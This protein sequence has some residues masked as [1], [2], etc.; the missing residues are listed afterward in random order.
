MALSTYAAPK[1]LGRRSFLRG[2]AAATGAMM[3]PRG[4]FADA[5]D[6]LLVWLPGGSDEELPEGFRM[7]VSPENSGQP[8]E[9]LGYAD[10][11]EWK[12]WMTDAYRLK[13][14]KNQAGRA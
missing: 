10:Y 12:A 14:S 2:T 3:L 1:G 4:A 11:Q 13:D 5:Q 7:L 8:Q 6:A 9:R